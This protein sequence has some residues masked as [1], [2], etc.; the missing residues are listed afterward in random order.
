M[1][2]PLRAQEAPIPAEV[3]LARRARRGDRE[4]FDALFER[5]FDPIYAFARRRS[6]D[7]AGAEALAEGIWTAAIAALEDYAGESCL[8]AWLHA[9]ARRVARGERGGD[10]PPER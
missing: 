7:A 2:E 9:V 3:A 4:A 5:Y 8:G 6:R 1:T 10:S